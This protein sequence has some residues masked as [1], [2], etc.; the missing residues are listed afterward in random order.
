MDRVALRTDFE[1]AHFSAPQL[2]ALVRHGWLGDWTDEQ[3]VRRLSRKGFT[4][5]EIVRAYVDAHR[6][7]VGRRRVP[8]AARYRAL[9]LPSDELSDALRS[10]RSLT[11]WHNF[12]HVGRWRSLRTWGWTL[13][14]LGIASVVGG[15]IAVAVIRRPLHCDYEDVSCAERDDWAP[16]VSLIYGGTPMVAGMLEL[17]AGIPM[18]VVA[19]RRRGRWVPGRRL[20]VADREELGRLAG[21]APT[22]RGPAP[23]ALVV[24]FGARRGGGLVLHLR[25]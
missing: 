14:A 1:D 7:G 20:D 13:T 19:R 10:E 17:A 23:T 22:R 8:R 25:F 11:D 4:S 6:A 3:T 16:L 12:E 24:P 9:R 21:G 5:N 18:V 15:I 2:R